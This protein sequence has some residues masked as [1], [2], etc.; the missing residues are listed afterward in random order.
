MIP[1]EEKPTKKSVSDSPVIL[2]LPN[3]RSFVHVIFGNCNVFES[4]DRIKSSH[5]A[6]SL[7]VFLNHVSGASRVQSRVLVEESRR[8][9]EGRR[10]LEQ[11]TLGDRSIS[12]A[13]RVT[14]LDS[15]AVFE[16]SEVFQLRDDR[17]NRRRGSAG[18][19]A[20]FLDPPSEECKWGLLVPLCLDWSDGSTIQV[21]ARSNWTY[22]EQMDLFAHGKFQQCTFSLLPVAMAS[23]AS[24]LLGN[25]NTFH[26]AASR[27][28]PAQNWWTHR[29]RCLWC[30]C[31]LPCS[32]DHAGF[33]PADGI[34]ESLHG[35]RVCPQYSRR[36]CVVRC[37]LCDV[38]STRSGVGRSHER[39]ARQ[40]SRRPRG[41]RLCASQRRAA[42]GHTV[43]VD[44]TGGN[45]TQRLYRSANTGTLLCTVGFVSRRDSHDVR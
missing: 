30:Y 28:L 24:P 41:L 40:S 15:E 35:Q 6:A 29:Q 23:D 36:K 18:V 4:S 27:S 43:L 25:S 38:V 7:L 2:P 13:V 42:G 19:G 17:C 16:V 21:G 5:S 12:S 11:N 20:D 9:L 8:N 22:A 39:S 34:V 32:T 1:K 44:A 37:E 45:R 10:L 3:W 26:G 33:A 31:C 14:L